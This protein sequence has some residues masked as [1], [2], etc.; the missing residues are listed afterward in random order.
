MGEEKGQ[1][2][3]RKRAEDGRKIPTTPVFQKNYAENII[4]RLSRG[5]DFTHFHTL[6]H[7]TAQFE[8]VVEVLT[9]PK[10]HLSTLGL[11]PILAQRPSH[12]SSRHHDGRA[13]ATIADGKVRKR[14]RHLPLPKD[15]LPRVD[16]VVRGAGEVNKV[17]YMPN[18]ERDHP[19]SM[20]RV[21]PAKACG[22]RPWPGKTCYNILISLTYSSKKDYQL[23]RS[24]YLRL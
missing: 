4:I 11:T 5:D 7:D 8:F 23:V 2:Q 9:R 21:P 13:S 18:I 6:P 14:R 3:P 10:H 22:R 17:A 20:H 12:G 15:G 16:D 1:K 19:Q 24:P